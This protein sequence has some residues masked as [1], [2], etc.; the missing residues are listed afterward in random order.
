MYEHPLREKRRRAGLTQVMLARASGVGLVTINR[1]ERGKQKMHRST[2][3]KLAEVLDVEP[4]WIAYH[5]EDEELYPVG[6][7]LTPSLREKTL[8]HIRRVARR[9]ALN[10]DDVDDLEAAGMEGLVKACGRFDPERGTPLEWYARFIATNRVRDEARRMY[11][12]HPGFGIK[13]DQE[14]RTSG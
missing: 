7:R 6:V 9:L 8:P 13:P 3:E 14:P 11:R 1:I 4:H 5:L 12:H 10:P 2:A